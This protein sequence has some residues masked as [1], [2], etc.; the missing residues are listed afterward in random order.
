[1]PLKLQATQL[2]KKE[3]VLLDMQTEA[4]AVLTGFGAA[5]G[6][7]LVAMEA[8]RRSRFSRVERPLLRTSLQ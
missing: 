5:P 3:S 7:F 6:T 1:M 4:L 2:P 8:K